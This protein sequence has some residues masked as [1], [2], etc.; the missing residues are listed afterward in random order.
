MPFST[1]HANDLLE[2][3]FNGTAIPDLAENDATGPS[4]NL[5]FAGHTSSPGVGGTQATNEVTYT[6]RSR[7]TCARSSGGFTVSTNT[8]VPVATVSFG[9]CTVGSETMTHFS[10]GTSGTPGAAG[11]HICHGTVTPNIAIAP[12]VTPQLTTATT[13]TLT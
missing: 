12:G 9:A 13:L 4:T 8:V 5:Y 11:Y 7:P 6:G 10:I 1:A 3:I 2:L